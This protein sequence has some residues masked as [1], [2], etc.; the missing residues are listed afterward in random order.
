[1]N[2]KKK[3]QRVELLVQNELKR[4]GAIILYKSHTCKMGPFWKGHDFANLFDIVAV[5]YGSWLFVGC[6]ST[7]S[8]F[9]S[10]SQRT[11]EIGT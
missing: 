11:S 1:M 10:P 8:H 5:E 2:T 6:A 3:G 4:Q 9:I 7:M